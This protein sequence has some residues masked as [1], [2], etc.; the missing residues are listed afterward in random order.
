ML[1]PRLHRHATYTENTLLPTIRENSNLSYD[2]DI[3]L[4]LNVTL[5]AQ[6]DPQDLPP[7][8]L[9]PRECSLCNRFPIPTFSWMIRVG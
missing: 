1:R 8:I 4:S 9:E 7:V 5:L 3:R 2:L 6:M